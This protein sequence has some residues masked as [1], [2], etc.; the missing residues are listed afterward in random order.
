M[1]S[2]GSGCEREGGAK[3]FT[4]VIAEGSLLSVSKF[5]AASGQP[6][7]CQEQVLLQL[8]GPGFADFSTAVN[9]TDTP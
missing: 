1:V 4:Q 5:E 3:S 6:D 9:H 7:S 2:A 8:R